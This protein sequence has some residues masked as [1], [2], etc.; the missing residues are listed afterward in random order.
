[1]VGATPPAWGRMRA[2]SNDEKQA[3][4][5]HCAR[6][7]QADAA[8]QGCGGRVR[9]AAH[10]PCAESP[11][12]RCDSKRGP[13]AFFSTAQALLRPGSTRP[14]SATAVGLRLTITTPIVVAVTVVASRLPFAVTGAI[15]VTVTV[16]AVTIAIPAEQKNNMKRE[17]I[18]HKK[19]SPSWQWQ[20]HTEGMQWGHRSSRRSS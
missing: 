13:Y 15:A 14:G 10:P 20:P 16:S 5:W 3:C 18:T 1:M 9:Q 8:A 6:A 7:I 19:N 11:A 4:G 17:A 12:S 2:T